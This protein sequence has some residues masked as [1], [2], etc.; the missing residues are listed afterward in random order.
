V[1]LSTQAEDAA[2]SERLA[3]ENPDIAA[4]SQYLLRDEHSHGR[5]AGYRTGI[6]KP[7]GSPKP[8]Y[9]GFALPLTVTREAAKG[10]SGFLLWGLVR[11]TTG[12]TDVRILIKP[13]PSPGYRTLG[14]VSTDAS[15]YWKLR[16]SVRGL[17]WRVSWRSPSGK[18][19]TGPAIAAFRR[20]S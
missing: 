19:Y 6:E 7:N 11:P 5:Y 8:S 18:V 13:S 12:A 14:V 9:Y 3:W 16:S 17:D 10:A 2:I 20:S 15:G 4:F 1:S